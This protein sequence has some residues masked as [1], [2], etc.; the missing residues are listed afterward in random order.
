MPFCHPTAVIDNRVGLHSQDLMR[1]K[2][3]YPTVVYSCTSSDNTVGENNNASNTF[4]Y[5]GNHNYSGG[6]QSGY[7]GPEYE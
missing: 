2:D 6:L 3:I 4:R 7:S 5:L 1:L